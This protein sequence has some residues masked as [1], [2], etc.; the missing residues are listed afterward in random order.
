M[1]WLIQQMEHIKCDHLYIIAPG[2]L[3]THTQYGGLHSTVWQHSQ[4]FTFSSAPC[5]V[6]SP[7]TTPRTST[8]MHT[9]CYVLVSHSQIS[10]HQIHVA[11]EGVHSRK[12]LICSSVGKGKK[13]NN[14]IRI[15]SAWLLVLAS[16]IDCIS[17]H[18]TIHHVCHCTCF[19]N[20]AQTG[21][22]ESIITEP[23]QSAAVE[24]RAGTWYMIH[25]GQQ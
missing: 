22:G 15:T 4:Q 8:D 23:F 10:C 18:N 3:T 12:L 1:Y 14:N 20:G 11:D 9:Q 17:I 2:A 21:N 5:H 25:P 6:T 16:I 13:N 19:C 24:W 7:H